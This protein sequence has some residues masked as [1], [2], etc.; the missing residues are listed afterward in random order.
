[1]TREKEVTDPIRDVMRSSRHGAGG[2]T[3]QF[4]EDVRVLYAGVTWLCLFSFRYIHILFYSAL[5]GCL[6]CGI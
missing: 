1:M 2:G 3:R 5:Q 6:L 4:W